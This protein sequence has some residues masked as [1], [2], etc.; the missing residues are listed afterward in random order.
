MN[1][2]RPWREVIV[3]WAPELSQRLGRSEEA[4][5]KDGLGALDF[6][7]NSSVEIRDPGGMTTRIKQAFALIRPKQHVVAVFSE[8]CGYLEFAL[9]ED[10]VVA[11]I[12]EQ[13][14]THWGDGEDN[15]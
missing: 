13:L 15:A 3:D 8:H 1:P 4:I 12:S 10:M 2:I 5:L 14:Y 7:S 9:L 11:E 6:A